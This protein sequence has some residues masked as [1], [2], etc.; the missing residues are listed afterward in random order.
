MGWHMFTFIVLHHRM[1]HVYFYCSPSQD[2]TCCLTF[3][4]WAPMMTFCW[5]E[6]KVCNKNC[7]NAFEDLTLKQKNNSK[8]KTA[9]QS[10][11]N[12]Q[13]LTWKV[14]R[15]NRFNTYY[16]P[17]TQFLYGGKSCSTIDMQRDKREEPTVTYGLPYYQ[18]FLLTYMSN[19]FRLGWLIEFLEHAMCADGHNPKNK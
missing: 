12:P 6:Q 1:A 10:R 19:I 17:S 15:S 11:P 2:D 7:E 5:W 16:L 13:T 9:K 18:S 8:L 4:V 14:I 3:S